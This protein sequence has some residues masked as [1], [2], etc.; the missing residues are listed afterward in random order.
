MIVEQK[1]TSLMNSFNVLKYTAYGGN[2]NFAVIYNTGVDEVK[3]LTYMTVEKNFVYVRLM[4]FLFCNVN[5]S[6]IPCGIA[7]IYFALKFIK[8]FKTRN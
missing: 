4:K 2:E 3:T 1:H 6:L 5:F 7:L 8:K